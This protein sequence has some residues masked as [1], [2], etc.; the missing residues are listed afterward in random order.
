YPKAWSKGDER[1]YPVPNE[2]NQALYEAYARKAKELKNVHF[3]GRLG[4][5]RYY[6]MDKVIGR[7]LDFFKDLES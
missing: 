4:E 6:D 2:A 7:T 3:I 1:Y 5:Y